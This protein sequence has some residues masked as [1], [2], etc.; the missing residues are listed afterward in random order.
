MKPMRCED[1]KKYDQGEKVCS[2]APSQLDDQVCLLRHIS[3]ALMMLVEQDTGGL[4]DE[5]DEWK[6][7]GENN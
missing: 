2:L 4:I 3:W 7:G 5:G 6:Y 1:C